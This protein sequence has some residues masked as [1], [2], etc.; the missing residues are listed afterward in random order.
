MSET[1]TVIFPFSAA[2]RPPK[3]KT[4]YNQRTI[5]M[6]FQ[7]QFSPELVR[8]YVL[9]NETHHPVIIELIAKAMYACKGGE[10]HVL[11]DLWLDEEFIE[12][13]YQIHALSATNRKA[14]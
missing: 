8:H 11:A 14:A 9:N 7:A 3:E 6:K 2:V 13:L 10:A 5:K 4:I 1:L 12:R